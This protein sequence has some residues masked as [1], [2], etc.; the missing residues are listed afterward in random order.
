M[1]LPGKQKILSY[2]FFST[3]VTL[4]AA[5]GS[6][7]VATNNEVKIL[8]NSETVPISLSMTQEAN[9]KWL[10]QQYGEKVFHLVCL[11]V[12]N[13]TLAEDI[14]QE[15]F[16][17]AY[18][19]L[20]NFRGDGDIKHWLFKIAMNEVKKHFRSWSFR[21]IWATVD[22]RLGKLLDEWVVRPNLLNRKFTADK[23]NRLPT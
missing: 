19:N 16:I 22:E 4:H 7:I 2:V 5:V 14:T 1:R 10:M 21:H 9:L 18:R 3:P 23:P 17:K 15:V 13:R 12:K 11:N 6:F 20:A 8:S